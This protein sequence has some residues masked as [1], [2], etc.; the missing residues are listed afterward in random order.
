MPSNKGYTYKS[1]GSASQGSQHI[2]R[3]AGG[4][5]SKQDGYHHPNSINGSYHYAN[6]NNGGKY[7]GNGGSTFTSA[8]GYRTCSGYGKNVGMK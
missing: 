1:S 5:S 7:D 4:S 8:S 6:P 3:D 2:P